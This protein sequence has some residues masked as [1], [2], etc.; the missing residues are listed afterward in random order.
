[1]IATIEVDVDIL[2]MAI[3]LRTE[4]NAVLSFFINFVTRKC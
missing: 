1:M 4:G 3:Y 2:S